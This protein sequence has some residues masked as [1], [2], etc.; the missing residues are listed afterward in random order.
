MLIVSY[1]LWHIQSPISCF[2]QY[3]GAEYIH[4][5]EIV[6]PFYMLSSLL[7]VDRHS[8]GGPCWAQRSSDAL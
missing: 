2:I 3:S 7:E 8:N 1:K 5:I 6:F 4:T